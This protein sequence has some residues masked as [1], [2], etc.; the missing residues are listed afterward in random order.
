MRVA[1]AGGTGLVGRYVVEELAAA[2]QE[3]VV[4]SRSRGVD[5]VTG[6][7]LDAAIAGVEAVVDVSN[8]TT[9]NAKKALSFFDGVGRTLLD[10]GER[11]GGADSPWEL[12]SARVCSAAE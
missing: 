3:P 4:L 8:V 6:A 7:R 9:M 11:A 10:A 12:A 1:V 2:G 5:L